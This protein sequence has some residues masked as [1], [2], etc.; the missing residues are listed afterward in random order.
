MMDSATPG[1]RCTDCLLKNSRV[2]PLI[3]GSTFRELRAINI[4]PFCSNPKQ[5]DSDRS[6]VVHYYLLRLTYC[7]LVEMSLRDS[8]QKTDHNQTG[9]G[10]SNEL[11]LMSQ[12]CAKWNMEISQPQPQ[13]YMTERREKER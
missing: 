2:L 5:E 3:E 4:F 12:K 9:A 8:C 6:G 13:Y 10:N 7:S 11:L 1:L